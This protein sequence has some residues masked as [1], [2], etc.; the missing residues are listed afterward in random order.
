MLKDGKILIGKSADAEMF[1]DPAMANRHGMIAG[2]TG[3]G[4]TVSLKVQVS[5]CFLRMSREILAL[6]P[7]WDAMRSM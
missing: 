1:L 2:A 3:T 5:P 4:K 7:R 6:L